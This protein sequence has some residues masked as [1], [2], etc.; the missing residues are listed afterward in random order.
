M[1]IVKSG[2]LRGAGYLAWDGIASRILRRQKPHFMVA[3]MPKSGSTFFSTALA[4]YP[5]FRNISLVP[6][7]GHR[8]Q[9][10]CQIQLSRYDRVSYVAQ[11]HIRNSALTQLLIAEYG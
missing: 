2:R 11:H 3:C 6:D 9:E 5:G 8:E 7:Y 1:D 10:L 4:E